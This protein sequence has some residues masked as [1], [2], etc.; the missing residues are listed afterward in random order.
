MTIDVDAVDQALTTTR[1]VRLRLD[2]ERPVDHQII[3]DC[4]DVAEQ[5]P[6]GETRAAAAGSSF[7]TPRSRPSWPSCTWSRPAGG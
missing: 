7:A 6:S 4:I 3:L 5:A 2:L 1:A